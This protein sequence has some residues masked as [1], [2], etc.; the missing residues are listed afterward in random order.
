MKGI[1]NNWWIHQERG[2]E[3]VAYRDNIEE[4][5]RRGVEQ[6]LF[7]TLIGIEENFE[8]SYSIKC[9]NYTLNSN[10]QYQH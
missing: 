6:F 8:N 7:P 10:L 1:N 9:N 3:N 4:R 5:S 2:I